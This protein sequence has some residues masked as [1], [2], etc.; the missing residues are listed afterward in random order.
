M[1]EFKV[2]QEKVIGWATERGI[3]DEQHGSSFDKQYLKF[4]SE[5]GELSS[6]VLKNDLAEIKDGIGDCIVCLINA[7]KFTGSDIEIEQSYFE[8]EQFITE[9]NECTP[10][11]II[12]GVALC[13]TQSSYEAIFN[14][15][16]L[17][18]K[19]GFKY[20]ECLNIAWEEIKDRK[21][22]MINGAFVKE[23]K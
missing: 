14:L 11:Q 19:L 7:A 3:F 16:A 8:T 12:M 23:T 20:L 15:I 5:L 18:K 2:L 6:G 10:E 1:S 9:I 4:L 17:E 22:Q 13:S 21:G